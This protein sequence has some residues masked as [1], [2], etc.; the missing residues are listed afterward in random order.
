VI[1]SGVGFYSVFLVAD[2]VEV[3][4]KHNDDAQHIW[5]SDGQ[6]SFAIIRDDDPETQ[7]GRGTLLRLHIKDDADEYLEERKIRELVKTYSQYIHYPILLEVEKDVEKEVPVDEVDEDN[8]GITDS[9]ADA[10]RTKTTTVKERSWE[11]LNQTQALWTRMPQEV[12]EDEYFE[13]F[14]EVAKSG[15][16][17]LAYEHFEASGSDVEFKAL[18]FVPPRAPSNFYDE[19][20]TRKPD[21]RLY[22]RR[23][24]ITD[25]FEDILP[26]YLRFVWGLVDSDTLPLNVSRETLQESQALKVIKRRL[27][28]KVLDMIMDIHKKDEER[29]ASGELQ[30][31][32]EKA[33]DKFWKQWGKS[34]KLGL[35]E[36]TSNRHRIAKLLRVK[37]SK[38]NGK[39]VS[40]DEYIEGMKKGQ[41]FIYFLSG[42]SDEEIRS[43]PLI[44]RLLAKDIEVI[45]FTEPVD[46][47]LIQHL[48]EYE[49]FK[50]QNAAKED[51]R[52]DDKEEKEEHKRLEKE[53]KDL[54]EW[55][56]EQIKSVDRLAQEVR[57]TTRLTTTP[58]IVVSAKF[59][60]SAH[61]EKIMMAQA[62]GD[63]ERQQYMRSQKIL[64]INPL[65]PMVSYIKGRFDQDREDADAKLLAQLMYDTALLESGYDVADP[66]AFSKSMYKMLNMA[67]QAGLDLDSVSAAPEDDVDTVDGDEAQDH[68][69]EL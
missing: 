30:E 46:E 37:T 5:T 47:I 12:K 28:K 10:P 53:Y 59:G 41:K 58:C 31:G 21:V 15:E 2:S 11:R 42:D 64:E 67:M 62:L 27:V 61:M 56:R 16:N 29:I 45:F 6:G 19:F 34:L 24:F 9:D 39:L 7:L 60:W 33:Y 32:D 20:Y 48:D 22:V 3:V 40:L 8:D 66:H 14:K 25:D 43:S 63:P 38:S 69:A 54:S 44:E 35:A 68:D 36:D 4:S 50:F 26:T 13:F 51:M 17:P 52:M 23:V 49:E 1:G 18:L 55:W 65:H 57:V